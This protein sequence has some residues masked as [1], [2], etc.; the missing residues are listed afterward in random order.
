MR[1]RG[2]V[3]RTHII[4]NTSSH[5]LRMNT[6]QLI[7]LPTLR[8]GH[9]HLSVSLN[10]HG[11]TPVFQPPRN[12]CVAMPLTANMDAY[13][14]MKKNDQRRPLYS[15]WKPA[16]S[17]LSASARSNG[18]RLHCAVAQVKYVQKASKVNGSWKTF[19][20]QKAPPC[21]RATVFRSMLPARMTGTSTQMAIGTS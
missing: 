12:R 17:S 1:S 6:A 16:T 2:S 7:R 15:V 18:A 14:A 11:S 20:F 13:S 4:T 9:G 10:S 5:A 3:Q 8:M 21:F 19:Q